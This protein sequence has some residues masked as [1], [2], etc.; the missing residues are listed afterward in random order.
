MSVVVDDTDPRIVYSAGWSVTTTGGVVGG[1]KH[2]ATT[3]GLTAS[4]TFTGT[5]VAVWG[6]VGSN[7]VQGWPST[8]YTID[9]NLLGTYNAPRVDPPHFLLNV[10]YFSSTTLDPGQHTLKIT[11]TNGTAP[12][13]Y[14]LDFITFIP[15]QVQTSQP[16]PTSL[17][18]PSSAS[19]PAST[20]SSHSEAATTTQPTSTSTTSSSTTRITTTGSDGFLTSTSIQVPAST[21]NSTGDSPTSQTTRGA[22]SATVGASTHSTNTGAI[23]GGV[24]AGIA[25]I[26]IM[27]VLIV[28]LRRRRTPRPDR[29][30]VLVEDMSQ[31]RPF[32][33][34][35]SAPT[36]PSKSATSPLPVSRPSEATPASSSTAGS[37]APFRDQ[38]PSVGFPSERMT[39]ESNVTL[40]FLGR[41]YQDN[42]ELTTTNMSETRPNIFWLYF[43]WPVHSAR[44]NDSHD[45]LH[46]TRHFLHTV[47][48]TNQNQSA[49]L[50]ALL[51]LFYRPAHR[52]LQ[53]PPHASPPSRAAPSA[54]SSFV[55]LTA[56]YH[57]RNSS[58]GV[59]LLIREDA[60]PD[61][62]P[63]GSF[64]PPTP[65][66]RAPVMLPPTAD[67]LGPGIG[68]ETV[69]PSSPPLTVR[70]TPLRTPRRC[71]SPLSGFA[72]A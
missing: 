7:D 35:A 71:P 41:L 11:N 38:T 27:V 51:A 68:L 36:R 23:A 61:A 25:I 21:M 43:L 22:D 56:L 18:P 64:P 49:P 37:H 50:T 19:S 14:W 52:P 42:H 30:E 40:F 1:G 32:G 2:G 69:S 28:F 12:N 53:F 29:R 34:F 55:A 33:A 26:A 46:H 60:Q 3:A 13:V 72:H 45:S 6:L 66:L 63:F 70:P 9:G 47:I 10:S 67:S 31:P 20:P 65:A 59:E 62:T 48:N 39:F 16:P 8:T 44:F 17:P 54:D 24:V 4:F 5:H 57:S 58:R 15:A